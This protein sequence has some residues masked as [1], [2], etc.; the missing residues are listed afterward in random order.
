MFSRG[1]SIGLMA[2]IQGG[3]P[4]GLR[5][6]HERFGGAVALTVLDTRHP[7]HHKELNGWQHIKQLT[8][9]CNH[10]RI[11]QRFRDELELHRR[12]GRISDACYRQTNG[13][14]PLAPAQGL[15][16]EGHRS[17]G[18]D[19]HEREGQKG[20]LQA[21]ELT[22]RHAR[23]V[24]FASHPEDVALASILNSKAPTEKLRRRD[25]MHLRTFRTIT[26]RKA[27]T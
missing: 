9:E 6:I 3:L 15:A 18:R 22:P 26:L 27:V 13:S 7:G 2:A 8:Q 16:E 19:V 10:D 4:D 1:A 25:S 24:A 21:P 12:E 11:A 20:S 17:D 5:R 14:P 23:A